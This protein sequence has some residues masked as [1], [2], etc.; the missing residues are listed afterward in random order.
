MITANQFAGQELGA[1]FASLKPFAQKH[2][3][4]PLCTLDEVDWE[5]EDVDVEVWPIP[6]SNGTESDHGMLNWDA[7]LPLAIPNHNI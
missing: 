5:V 4:R 7:G 1:V 3:L 6:P 2:K